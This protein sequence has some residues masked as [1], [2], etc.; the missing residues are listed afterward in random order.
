MHFHS[1]LCK[2][3]DIKHSDKPTTSPYPISYDLGMGVK[4]QFL[5]KSHLS[6]CISSILVNLLLPN[7]RRGISGVGTGVEFLEKLHPTHF[8]GQANARRPSSLGWA[9]NKVKQTT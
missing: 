2:C 6:P 8:H 9:L 4:V 7:H 1:N 3:P 5:E